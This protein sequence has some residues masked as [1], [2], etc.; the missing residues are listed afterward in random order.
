MEVRESLPRHTVPSSVL[1]SGARA[2]RVEGLVERPLTLRPDDL[3]NLPRAR[4]AEPFTCE[5]GWQTTALSWDGVRL[6]DVLDLAGPR[7]EGGWVRVSAGDYT[8]P[9][10]VAAAAEAVLADSLD[11]EPLSIEHGAPWRLVL[12]GASCFTSVKWVDRLEL[13]AEPGDA[14]GGRIA[15]ARLDRN[16]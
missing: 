9:L 14:S 16:D 1:A 11:G 15:R 2:L 6:P 7:A 3:A 10:P 8:V 13:A 5:E 4:L 12:P